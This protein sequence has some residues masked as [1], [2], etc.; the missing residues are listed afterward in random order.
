M[1]A[2]QIQVAAFVISEAEALDPITVVI[3][4]VQL[5]KGYITISCYGLAWSG[6]WGAMGERNVKQ[7]IAQCDIDYIVNKLSHERMRKRDIAYLKRIVAAVHEWAK[8]PVCSNCDTAM[9]EGCGG[10]F[11]AEKACMLNEARNLT[12][13]GKE[14]ET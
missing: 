3:H 8:Y 5:G 4:D 12:S 10:L 14:N 11:K 1:K 2:Q 6:Y 9:P 7:F 13:Q